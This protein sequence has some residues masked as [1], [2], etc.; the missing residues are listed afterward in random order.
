MAIGLK[1][2]ISRLKPY[3]RW[4]I[5]GGTC[6]FLATTLRQ[7]WQDVWAMQI[8]ARGWACLTLALGV[9]LLAHIWA[10]W[11][12][13]WMLWEFNQPQRGTWGIYTYL[14]TNIAKY[15]PGNIWHFYGR[16]RAVQSLGVPI[17]IAI[18]SVVMEPLL[19]AAA[20]LIL[21]L[22][23]IQQQWPWYLFGLGALLIGI[24]P[25]LLNPLLHRLGR[26]KAAVT[27]APEAPEQVAQSNLRRY[28]WK[29]LLGEIGFVMLRGLGFI[30]AIAALGPVQVNQLLL[31]LSSFSLAWLLGLIIPGAPG[32][33]GVFE[34][35][36]VALLQSQ[37]SPS[38]ILGGVAWYRLIS[39]LA[40]AGGAGLVWLDNQGS[41]TLAHPMPAL[42]PQ[43][44]PSTAALSP[45]RD[46]ME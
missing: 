36:A 40:E 3:L 25:R 44:N 16:V 24:H 37:L 34:A 21:A 5:L 31:L 23:I 9:T 30:M 12:W 19:M 17:G 15:L 1:A 10:G 43:A 8:T 11:V 33:L 7:H 29:P 32:G 42:P 13:S 28:P 6:F 20:A 26:A 35:T 14:T 27:H 18:V 38:L 39:I 45:S 46:S 22:L 2:W 4:L 41:G